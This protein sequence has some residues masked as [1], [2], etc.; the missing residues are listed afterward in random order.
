MPIEI[1]ELIIR[2]AVNNG[3]NTFPSGSSTTN[4][5]DTA[6]QAQIQQS[7]DEIMEILK[8]KNER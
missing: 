4:S 8:N 1:K 3:A 7:I 6:A 5:V 2:G